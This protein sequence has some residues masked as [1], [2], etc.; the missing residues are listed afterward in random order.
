MADYNDILGRSKL[1]RDAT[2]LGENTATRVGGVLVD[3]CDW[4]KSLQD[5]QS[6]TGG[7]D[8]PTSNVDLTQ[9]TWWGRTF[10][11]GDTATSKRIVGAMNDVTSITFIDTKMSKQ[12]KLYLDSNGDLCFDGNFYA[13][14]GIT[15]LGSGG[16]SSGGSTGGDGIS[17]ITIKRNGTVVN[18]ADNQELVCKSI[19]FAYPTDWSSSPV[20]RTNDH[21]IKIDLSVIAANAGG[22]SSANKNSFTVYNGDSDDHV[23][24]NGIDA[25]YIK[26]MDGFTL[27]RKGLGYEISCTGSGGS[28]SGGSTTSKLYFTKDDS[29]ESWDGSSKFNLKFGS[30]INASFS[31]D[32]SS[33]TI[34]AT[35]GSGSSVDLSNYV[36]TSA[37][38]T[39]LNDYL[40]TTGNAASASKL[41]TTRTFWGQSFNG[42]QNVS[43]DMS[44]VGAISFSS[45]DSATGRP[46]VL[47]QAGGKSIFGLNQ[48]KDIFIGY[49]WYQDTDAHITLYG[50]KT[51]INTYD[52]SS[53]RN[54]WF[55]DN[56]F[57]LPDDGVVN[58]AN[59]G[60]ISWDSTNNAFKIEG[61]VYATGG[62]TALGVSNG[63]TTSNNV[64]FTFNSVTANSANFDRLYLRKEYNY[65]LYIGTTCALWGALEA[66]AI[67]IGGNF[68]QTFLTENIVINS[69]TKQFYSIARLQAANG[70]SILNGYF[71]V[72]Y[73]GT[74]YKFDF[75]KAKELGLL[76]T[77]GTQS[78]PDEVNYANISQ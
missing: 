76:T 66:N 36:T 45:K 71:D 49:G 34:S 32:H 6:S 23:S 12:K 26:F 43:G 15:A 51:L 17:G 39:K 70:L 62:I 8:E 33:V 47:I 30:G 68:T 14:G 31:S 35:G 58:I 1:V 50:S 18:T 57:I 78:L 9:Y 21:E 20:L 54:W 40:K 4:I 65:G 69:S 10:G 44:N 56:Q 72:T 11:D 16:S 75:A 2:E 22:G 28:S 27:Q 48:N 63:S 61:N 7:D 42:E 24:Y 77:T 3:L 74:V 38:N 52:G 60:K 53:S 5:N 55:R 13:T 67:H 41:A 59:K 29:Q 37:L 46:T 73:N 25:A 19:N 64:D